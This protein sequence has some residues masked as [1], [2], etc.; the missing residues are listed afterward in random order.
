LYASSTSLNKK[1]GNFSAHYELGFFALTE[2]FYKKKIYEIADK[3][4]GDFFTEMI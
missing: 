3:T 1:K 2:L 4:L